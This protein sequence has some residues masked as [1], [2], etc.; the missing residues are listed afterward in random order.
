MLDRE[1]V[2]TITTITAALTAL[3]GFG[4]AYGLDNID[5]DQQT[6]IIVTVAAAAALIFLLGFILRQMV[7][8]RRSV[9]ANVAAAR[10]TVT[11]TVIEDVP[12]PI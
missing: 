7:W 1:P 12:P 5:D 8:S 2:V 11:G 4:I 9:E 6:A 3:I 10:R